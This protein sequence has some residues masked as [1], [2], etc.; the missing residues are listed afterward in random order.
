[1]TYSIF[2]YQCNLIRW[3]RHNAAVGFSVNGTFFESHP[4]SNNASVVNIDCDGAIFNWTNVVYRIDTSKKF[5][6][7]NHNTTSLYIPYNWINI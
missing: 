3:T 2:T 6:Q 4:L 5:L 7:M 1:M